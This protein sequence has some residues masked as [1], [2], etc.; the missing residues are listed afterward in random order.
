MRRL[1]DQ[2]EP[3][4]F[5]DIEALF[6]RDMNI[7]LSELFS[8]FDPNPIGVASLAQ[9]HIAHHRS[10]GKQVAV[11]VNIAGLE[12]KHSFYIISRFSILIWPNFAILIW[13]WLR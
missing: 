12:M 6:L 7:P 5:E 4:P 11:K 9:V 10:S 3:T 13:K 1:Q 8:E 2:C